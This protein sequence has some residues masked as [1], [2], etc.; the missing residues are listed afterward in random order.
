M[1]SVVPVDPAA[2]VQP[3][4]EATVASE[5]VCPSLPSGLGHVLQAGHAAEYDHAHGN[6]EEA[7]LPA[8]ATTLSEKTKKKRRQFKSAA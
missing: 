1:T 4:P 6:D 8:G 3:E 5:P 7:E 2:A